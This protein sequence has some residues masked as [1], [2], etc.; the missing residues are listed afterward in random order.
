MLSENEFKEEA[1]GISSRL[2]GLLLV[3]ITLVFVGVAVLMV[4]FLV[5]G[6]SSGFGGVILIGP[7]PIVFGAGSGT[8]WLIAISLIVAVISFVLF[9]I[10]NRRAGKFS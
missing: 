2:I 6:G 4:A 10:M 3:G 7:I 1:V 8:A 9:W 5:F